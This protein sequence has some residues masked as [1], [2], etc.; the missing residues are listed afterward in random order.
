[1]KEV[2][3]G[4][5]NIEDRPSL[6]LWGGADITSEIKDKDRFETIFPRGATVVFPNARHY[7]QEDVPEEICMAIRRFLATAVAST[8]LRPSGSGA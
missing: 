2:E 8:E 4:L 5:R 7:L 6:I 1:M 3:A